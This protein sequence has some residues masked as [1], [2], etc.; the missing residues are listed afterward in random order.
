MEQEERTA[1]IRK[2]KAE[3]IKLDC[4]VENMNMDLKIKRKGLWIG[5]AV[6]ILGLMAAL[7]K[8]VSDIYRDHM[9][10]TFCLKQPNSKLC[11]K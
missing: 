3:K 4:E 9:K 1:N 6:G 2:L 5:L 7:A 10:Y 8:P 11:E